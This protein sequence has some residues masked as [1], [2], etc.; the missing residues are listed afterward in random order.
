MNALGTG[1][2]KGG[3]KLGN[4]WNNYLVAY[5]YPNN[6]NVSIHSTQLGPVFGDVCCRFIGTEGVA[7][8]HYSGG[9]F[10]RYKGLGFGHSED[11]KRDQS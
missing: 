1:G 4:T 3:P 5:Q 11:R 2:I 10:I 9:V 8:A 7:E 6:I